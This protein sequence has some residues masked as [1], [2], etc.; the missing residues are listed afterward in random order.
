[1]LIFWTFLLLPVLLHI[2]VPG[3][4]TV[5]A[6]LRLIDGA[7]LSHSAYAGIEAVGA[8]RR[9]RRCRWD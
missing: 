2:D 9:K 7:Y 1:M 5:V 8:G 3:L 4:A 6:A